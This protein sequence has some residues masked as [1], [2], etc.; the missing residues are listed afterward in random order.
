LSQKHVLIWKALTH[1]F[2]N[3]DTYVR[4]V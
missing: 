1:L 4:R 2:K 3:N